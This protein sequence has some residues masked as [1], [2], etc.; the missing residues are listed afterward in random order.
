M[1]LVHAD[2]SSALVSVAPSRARPRLLRRMG[3]LQLRLAWAFTTMHAAGGP[4]VPCAADSPAAVMEEAH[5]LCMPQ[6]VPGQAV[7]TMQYV[8][9]HLLAKSQWASWMLQ[10]SV[11][12]DEH[13][14]DTCACACL[15]KLLLLCKT[16]IFLPD[17]G[18]AFATWSISWLWWLC[19]SMKM[20]QC[21]C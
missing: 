10:W 11:I 18:C 3:H 5:L 16:L 4:P 1:P 13:L 8:S 15:L 12:D 21:A 7:A 2:K 17:E 6:N 19:K 14:H 9:S 20:D